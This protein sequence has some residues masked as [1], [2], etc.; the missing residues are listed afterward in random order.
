MAVRIYTD[1]SV[2]IAVAA[3]LR[4]RGVDSFSALDSGNLGFTDE[5]QLEFAQREGAVLFTHDTDFL[6]LAQEW[7]NKQRSYPGIIYAHPDRV[8][9]GE[10]VRRL[11]EIADMTDPDDFVNHIEFL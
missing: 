7:A 6:R 9:V 3:G 5:A 8:S 2:P 11:K 4:R 10:C 1:E